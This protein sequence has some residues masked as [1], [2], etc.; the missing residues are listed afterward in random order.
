[1]GMEISLEFDALGIQG[2]QIELYKSKERVGTYYN[3]KH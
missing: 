1:M 3:T 2:I